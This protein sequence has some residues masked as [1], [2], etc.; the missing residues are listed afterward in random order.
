MPTQAVSHRAAS[1]HWPPWSAAARSGW[2]TLVAEV[3]LARVSR[4]RD[5]IDTLG[6]E[7]LRALLR[8]VPVIEAPAADEV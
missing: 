8:A 2:A 7:D 4:L 3:G 6:D 1:R 5:R